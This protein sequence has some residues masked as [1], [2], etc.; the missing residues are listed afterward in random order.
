MID[1]KALDK[2]LQVAFFEGNVTRSCAINII[3]AYESAKTVEP[4]GINYG[5]SGTSNCPELSEEPIVKSKAEADYCAFIK[6]ISKLPSAAEPSG[7]VV[8]R[9]ARA[10]DSYLDSQS[11]VG[12]IFSTHECAKAAIAAMGDAGNYSEHNQIAEV[13]VPEATSPAMHTLPDNLITKFQRLK[14]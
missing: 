1:E 2:A 4:S 8:E 14:E 5:E 13:K 11:Q 10:I 3:K 6:D 9:V 12:E 7:D